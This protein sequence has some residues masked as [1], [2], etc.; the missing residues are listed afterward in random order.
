MFM[1][2][3]ANCEY[4]DN[5][6][7]F[8]INNELIGLSRHFAWISSYERGPIANYAS[9]V[10][11]NNI[12]AQIQLFL[13]YADEGLRN[14]YFEEYK[15]GLPHGKAIII[16]TEGITDCKHMEYHWNFL[17][18]D[19]KWLK[20]DIDFEIYK[21]MMDN[22]KNTSRPSMGGDQLYNM[23][24]SLSRGRKN[25]EILVF[26]ADRDTDDVVRKL[27]DGES[28]FK[29]WGNNVYS[30][31]LPVPRHRENTPRI[32]IEHYYVDEEIKMEFTCADG[33]KRRLYI[34]SEFDEYGRAIAI[35]RFCT[36]RQ[37]CGGN[38]I[39]IIDGSSNE[40]VLCLTR[41]DGI[42]YALSKMRFAEL[43]CSSSIMI[44][45]TTKEAFGR[46]FE[47]ILSIKMDHDRIS[48]NISNTM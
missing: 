28:K 43:M 13:P 37:A 31:V 20:L 47:V 7:Y 14:I 32:C 2:I 17:R 19:S 5:I 38:S 16:Y 35:D 8:I 4:I 46:L 30:L 10:E 6:T 34:G 45:D 40:R 29:Y 36:N 1:D 18:H 26:I 3:I 22:I 23:C 25:R 9:R 41:D 39:R 27:S 15:N 12:I 42:N 33:I 21:L 44:S 48:K 11:Q 24:L